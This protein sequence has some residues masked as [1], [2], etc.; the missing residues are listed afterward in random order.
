M[1]SAVE[2]TRQVKD[3]YFASYWR[4]VF[5]IIGRS[6]YTSFLQI[7]TKL[8]YTKENKTNLIF[9]K[10]QLSSMFDRK[11][12]IVKFL[13]CLKAVYRSGLVTYLL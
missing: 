1:L 8:S 12:L 13:N 6:M 3:F 2:L 5:S 7:T 4:K 10:F 11:G 9:S